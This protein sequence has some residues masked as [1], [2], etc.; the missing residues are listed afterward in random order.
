MKNC[1]LCG[2]PTPPEEIRQ[3]DSGEWVCFSCLPK[4]SSQD[5][6]FESIISEEEQGGTV[7]S[8]PVEPTLVYETTSEAGSEPETKQCPKCLMVIPK[9]A[10]I[11]F[12][13]RS[14]QPKEVQSLELSRESARKLKM[15]LMCGSIIT[16]MLSVICA[17]RWQDISPKPAQPQTRRTMNLREFREAEQEKWDREIEEEDAILRY[18]VEKAVYKAAKRRER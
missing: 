10:V 8:E 13:C 3:I 9:L 2:L 15:I 14:E 1:E 5:D 4:E 12:H 17:Y 16:I 6:L 11:C 7:E 18:E